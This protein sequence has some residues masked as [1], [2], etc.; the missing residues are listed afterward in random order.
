MLIGIVTLYRTRGLQIEQFGYAAFGLTVFPYSSMSFVN[1]IANFL[2][3]TYPA[4]YIVETELLQSL[5]REYP[6]VCKITGTV[7]TVKLLPQRKARVMDLSIGTLSFV[8][9]ATCIAVIGGMSQWKA[10]LAIA[11]LVWT[12]MWFCFNSLGLS[13]EKHKI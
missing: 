10:K 8:A 2:Q 7:G 3:P 12:T 11:Q 4:L 1:L 9:F 13:L 6:E 5:R